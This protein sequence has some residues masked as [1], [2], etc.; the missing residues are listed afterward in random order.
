M[1]NLSIDNIKQMVSKVTETSERIGSYINPFLLE[2]KG[3][4]Q[5]ELELCHLGKFLLLLNNGYTL[6]K[7]PEEK[8]DF[9]LKK[10]NTKVGLEHEI[11][12]NNRLKKTEGTV[13]DFFKNAKTEFQSTYPEL[14]FLANIWYN[15]SNISL[16]K[17]E[18][19][20]KKN[21]VNK[22]IHHFHKTGSLLPNSVITDISISPHSKLAFCPNPGAYYVDNATTQDIYN[23]ILKKEKKVESY[24]EKTNIKKQWLLIVIGGCEASG[25][26]VPLNFE[27]PI[28]TDN[29]KF[30]KIYLLHDFEEKLYTLK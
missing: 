14:K 12:V 17:K 3:D 22:V 20:A 1:E 6:D 27:T 10:D 9:I 21:E 13:N 19:D 7:L 26:D 16:K 4:S 11:L 5:K 24:I 18:Y 8:P 23:A 25:Y 2:V 30:E 28:I 29:S 15:N